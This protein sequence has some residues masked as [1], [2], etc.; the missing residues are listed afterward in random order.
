MSIAAGKGLFAGTSNERPFPCD[1]VNPVEVVMMS[2]ND[3]LDKLSL[4]PEFRCACYLDKR[5]SV[6]VG[7][8][9]HPSAR[10]HSCIANNH[11]AAASGSS[12]KFRTSAPRA[13]GGASQ[14]SCTCVA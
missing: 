10:L 2:M 12:V 8:Y 1:R 5:K 9:S 4:S 14:F 13:S 11:N 6:P 7:I 3:S